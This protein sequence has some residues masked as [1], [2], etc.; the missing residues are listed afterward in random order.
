MNTRHTFGE[1]M[2]SGNR[3]LEVDRWLFEV[4]RVVLEVRCQL[5]EV[6]CRLM[7]DGC[8]LM[9]VH[10]VKFICKLYFFMRKFIIFSDAGHTQNIGFLL[11]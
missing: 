7:E 9:E 1:Q 2:I 5:L 11:F 3:L 8:R 10:G 6:S 4:D